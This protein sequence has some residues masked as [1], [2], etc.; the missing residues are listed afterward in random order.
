MTRVTSGT[1]LSIV[2]VVIL[3]N[4]VPI[5]V[6]DP[7]KLQAPTSK[8]KTR[9]N[10]ASPTA[11]KAPFNRPQKIV[12]QKIKI[13]RVENFHKFPA[14]LHKY[15]STVVAVASCQRSS[16]AWCGSEPHLY[17]RL[18]TTVLSTWGTLRVVDRSV[19]A[20]SSE[21]R[22]LRSKNFCIQPVEHIIVFKAQ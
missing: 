22:K 1:G 10:G 7:V 18:K 3:S 9:A 4:T 6:E 16:I 12:G 19:T 20:E 15:F 13:K 14:C 2:Y 17:V 11:K 5:H 8:A 21:T